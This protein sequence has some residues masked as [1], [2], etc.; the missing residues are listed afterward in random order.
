MDKFN[1]FTN[2][3]KNKLSED[4]IENIQGFYKKNNDF[5]CSICDTKVNYY[6][7]IDGLGYICIN[8]YSF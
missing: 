7:Y 5:K 1:E 4:C 8:C 3:V 2:L 6:D